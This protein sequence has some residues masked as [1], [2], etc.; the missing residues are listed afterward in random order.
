MR[1]AVID[2]GT[3]T[4]HLLIVDVKGGD[5]R[6]IYREKIAVRLG[7]DGISKGS[8]TSEAWKRA[9][10]TLNTFSEVIKEHDTTKT[11][12]TATS[13]IRNAKNGQQLVADIKEKVGIEVRIISG[14]QEAEYIFYGVR[15]AMD[16][17]EN[18]SL[19]MDIGGG[20]IE[21]IIASGNKINWLQSFEIGG[22]RLVDQFHHNDPITQEEISKLEHYIFHQLGPLFKAIDRHQPLTLIGSSG[23]FDTLSEIHCNR[24]RK[25]L[26]PDLTELP[27]TVAS[28][29]KIFQELITKNR[30]E[31][32]KI[33]GM[34]PLRVDMIV[35]AVI[36]IKYI[37]D[38]CGL[39]NIRVSA[40]ALKEGLLLNTI[41]QLQSENTYR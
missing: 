3:N 18:P 4:F 13:A 17:G 26:N 33:K 29:E 21:F 30:E 2:M 1:V 25:E 15:K 34:I 40:F 31:R 39:K 12:A 8:I 5:F 27:L 16:I 6:E 22:Q 7:Q 28:F 38:T 36:L 41:D 20:S 19:I 35:V 24:E 32:L 10:D 11:F 14:I 23:T 9:L 37:L